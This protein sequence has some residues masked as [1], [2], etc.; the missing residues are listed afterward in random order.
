[1]SICHLS[2]QSQEGSSTVDEH[3]APVG[4]GGG[5]FG[6]VV[7][8]PDLSHDYAAVKLLFR[9]QLSRSKGVIS[10]RYLYCVWQPPA[11]QYSTLASRI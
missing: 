10:V 11:L 3:D 8:G 9:M 6:L 5:S 4:W 7:L 2:R 1:M